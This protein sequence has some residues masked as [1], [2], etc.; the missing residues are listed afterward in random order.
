MKYSV[1]AFLNLIVTNLKQIPAV[2]DCP[3]SVSNNT[4]AEW[5]LN[6]LGGHPNAQME[7]VQMRD[8]HVYLERSWQM[9]NNEPTMER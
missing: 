9:K 3:D 7:S 2:V 8:L 1:I 6:S 5:L 4:K